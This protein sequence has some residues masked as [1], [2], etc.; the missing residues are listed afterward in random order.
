M[1]CLKI[2]IKKK[3]S[4]EDLPMRRSVTTCQPEVRLVGPKRAATT[5]AVAPLSQVEER[6]SELELAEDKS[7]V[8]SRC[9]GTVQPL[10]DRED[11]GLAGIKYTAL[12]EGSSTEQEEEHL[13]SSQETEVQTNR[14]ISF[15]SND[16]TLEISIPSFPEYEEDS[17]NESYNDT[18]ST[19]SNDS[20]S[21]ENVHKPLKDLIFK[22]NKELYNMDSNKVRIKV[23]LSKKVPSL[24]PKR[25]INGASFTQ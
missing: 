24:H 16:S 10:E 6:L 25:N 18:L 2:K 8:D 15:R 7:D 4:K 13:S 17:H 3:S 12:P 1:C 22:T 19:L 23:G 11:E 14:E 20:L 5:L 21:H 9:H